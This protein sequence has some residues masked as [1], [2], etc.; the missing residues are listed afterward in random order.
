MSS[1]LRRPSSLPP[2]VN[3]AIWVEVIVSSNKKTSQPWVGGFLIPLG[4]VRFRRYVGLLAPQI[5]GDDL[6]QPPVGEFVDAGFSGTGR[7]SSSVGDS[8]QSERTRGVGN[9]SEDYAPRAVRP[10]NTRLGAAGESGAVA[11]F[12][13]ATLQAGLGQPTVPVDLSAQRPHSGAGRVGKVFQIGGE[14]FLVK[15]DRT[16][17]SCGLSATA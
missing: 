16:I 9:G 11:A 6:G 4:R 12:G 15:A 13:L 7:V 5:P 1:C 10:G 14:G 8:A 17:T 3:C 2:G